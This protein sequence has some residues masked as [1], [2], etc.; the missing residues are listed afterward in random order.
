MKLTLLLLPDHL[1][2]CQL[3]PDSPFPSWAVGNNILSLTRST[4]ELSIVC[5]STAVPKNIIAESGWRALKIQG[6]LDFS[7]IG[8][9]TA[10]ST[11]L[12]E[13]EISIF[14]ISTYN[15]DYLLIK[16]NNIIKGKQALSQAGY[17]ILDP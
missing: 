7:Q 11:I 10:L 14:A 17:K 8:I 6:P 15:T 4:E 12:A 9:L 5:E 13:A 2:V 16:E 3:S 1:T